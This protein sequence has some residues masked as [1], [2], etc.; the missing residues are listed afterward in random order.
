ML[1]PATCCFCCAGSGTQH[2][3]AAQLSAHSRDGMHALSLVW[4]G[5]GPSQTHSLASSQHPPGWL[6]PLHSQ[7]PAK[8]TSTSGGSLDTGVVP[9]STGAEPNILSGRSHKQQ[10]WQPG[11]LL[12]PSRSAAAGAFTGIGSGSS[13]ESGSNSST[14]GGQGCQQ[15]A[16][17]GTTTLWDTVSLSAWHAR[18]LSSS[19]TT[20]SSTINTSSM[21]HPGI[22][23]APHHSSTGVRACLVPGDDGSTLGITAAW[24]TDPTTSAASGAGGQVLVGELSSRVPVA[25]GVTLTAGAVLLYHQQQG[26]DEPQ[27]DASVGS[28]NSRMSLAVVAGSQWR[29]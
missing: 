19:S 11:Q 28:R 7:Q 12:L 17:A 14:R 18:Q 10:H 5:A 16:V 8:A 29:F 24:A 26:H 6:D 21:I 23:S 2:T 22:A 3:S 9:G 13:A 15:V 20:N 4:A 27:P 25:D 1:P